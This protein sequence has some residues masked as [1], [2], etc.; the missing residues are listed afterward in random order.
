MDM[1][2]T[3]KRTGSAGHENGAAADELHDYLRSVHFVVGDGL[4][5][6]TRPWP[7]D[8]RTRSHASA[9]G[10]SLEV[11]DDVEL[12]RLVAD[13][14]ADPAS[15]P[16]DVEELT[17][18][19]RGVATLP[20]GIRKIRF[21]EEAEGELTIRLP[22]VDALDANLAELSDPMRR[23]G[24]RMPSFYADQQRPG[25]GP[26]LTPVDMFLAR[27]GDMALGKA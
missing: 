27:L 1:K 3:E 8:D 11:V 15:R 12:G 25:I 22:A 5:A 13:W 21:V 24:C 14:A 23:G 19:L 2:E 9:A 10:G 4:D 16:S 17:A 7:G 20:D 6:V 18:Q 26:M